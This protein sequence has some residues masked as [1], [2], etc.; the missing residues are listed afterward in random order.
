MEKTRYHPKWE[1]S[2]DLNEEIKQCE[3]YIK[4]FQT[5]T[6]GYKYKLWRLENELRTTKKIDL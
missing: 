4:M 3:N 2:R 6:D 5:I 1:W